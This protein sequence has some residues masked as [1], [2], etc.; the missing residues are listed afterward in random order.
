[1]MSDDLAS[2]A[3]FSGITRLFP[4]PNLVFFPHVLQPLHIF[5]ARYRQMTADALAS[6]RLIA[7][8]LLQSG[9]EADYEGRPAVHPVACLG[10]IL[11]EQRLDDGRYNILLRG[12]C[13]VGLTEEMDQGKLYRSARV[14]LIEDVAV[15]QGEEA[16]LR[17]R[18]KK[19]VARWFPAQ[20]GVR[21]QFRQLLRGDLSLGALADIIAFALPLD[22][23][24]KQELLEEPRASQRIRRLL[25]Y[26]ETHSPSS[27]EP[28]AERK[29]PPEFSVN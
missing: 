19:V 4:L 15:P 3:D 27:D 26:L 25:D 16:R 7:L 1:V 13:R 20:G 23:D 24:L 12:L 22:L 6:D 18:V 17:R 21:E 5:E 8:V 14:Q 2:L 11:A 10:R 9:W 29:F 28:P